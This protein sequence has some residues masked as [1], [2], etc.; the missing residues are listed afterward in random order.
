MGNENQ[1]NSLADFEKKKDRSLRIMLEC[2]LVTL[3][4]NQIQYLENQI[5]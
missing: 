2:V 3:T 1:I 4:N 5:Q